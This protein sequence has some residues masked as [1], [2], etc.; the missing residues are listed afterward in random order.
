MKA[1]IQGAGSTHRPAA[2]AAKVSNAQIATFA[3]SGTV[4][5]LFVVN[6][7]DLPFAS[8]PSAAVQLHQTGHS[9][10]LQHFRQVKVGRADEAVIL[11]WNASPL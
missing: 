6:G 8:W 7:P 3:K 9:F 4:D 5:F 11:C 1:A 10:I 2:P